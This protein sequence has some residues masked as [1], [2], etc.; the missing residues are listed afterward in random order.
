MTQ[1]TIDDLFLS[2]NQRFAEEGEALAKKGLLPKCTMILLA[3]LKEARGMGLIPP[4][5]QAKFDLLVGEVK[6]NLYHNFFG[7]SNVSELVGELTS[8]GLTKMANHAKMGKYDACHDDTSENDLK[9]FGIGPEK[10]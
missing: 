9:P 2:M 5:K 10:Q 1:G 7:E 6:G 3:D 8:L 4:A